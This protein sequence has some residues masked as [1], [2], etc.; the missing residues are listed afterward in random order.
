MKIICATNRINTPQVAEEILASNK[1]DLISMARPFLAD[2][3]FVS[4][5]RSGKVCF[6]LFFFF[7]FFFFSSFFFLD[8]Q[9]LHRLQSGVLGS[10]LFEK[11]SFV[12]G[13]SS[14]RK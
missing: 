4:K 13:E 2:E 6:M 12:F 7:C 9:H 3:A 8:D 10:H 11:E 14:R 5:A 1:A